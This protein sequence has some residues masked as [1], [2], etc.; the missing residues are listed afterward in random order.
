MGAISDDPGLVPNAHTVAHN[1]HNNKRSNTLSWPLK[2]TRH[3]HAPHA[4]AG[5][6]DTQNK[7]NL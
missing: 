3:T 7:M 2:A 5:E 1:H 4:L 6:T